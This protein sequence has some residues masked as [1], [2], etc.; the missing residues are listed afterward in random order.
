MLWR[1]WRGL[2]Q[3][4]GQRRGPGKEEEEEEAAHHGTQNGLGQAVTSHQH[5]RHRY[6][7]RLYG[8]LEH[9]NAGSEAGFLAAP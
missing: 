9:Q 5:H 3:L 8:P 7:R 1:G 6:K 2:D 4:P